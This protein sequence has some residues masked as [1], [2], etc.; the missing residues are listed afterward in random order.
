M[1][2]ETGQPKVPQVV[3]EISGTDPEIWR[4]NNLAE[5]TSYQKLQAILPAW[6]KDEN[7]DRAERRSVSRLIFGL[8]YFE[9][10]AV[11]GLLLGIGLKYLDISTDLLK[12]FFPFLFAQ[13]VGLAYL[14]V[15]SLFAKR[16]NL[17]DLLGETGAQNGS[18]VRRSRRSPARE[19]TPENPVVS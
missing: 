7:S 8:L 4:P 11:I 15:R 18:A 16:E 17:R 3:K 5:W 10:I 2:T 6:V 9:V 19:Q 12:I 14:V 1:S 13:V